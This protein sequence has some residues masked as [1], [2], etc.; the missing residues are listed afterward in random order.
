MEVK[1]TIKRGQSLCS[2]PSIAPCV[3]SAKGIN[4]DKGFCVLLLVV[5][6]KFDSELTIRN[7]T[8]IYQQAIEGVQLRAASLQAVD[9]GFG[10]W[11]EGGLDEVFHSCIVGEGKG[12]RGFKSYEHVI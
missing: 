7:S 6:E 9:G 4:G 3:D 1:N 8:G 2:S 10:S 11:G 12:R 5:V